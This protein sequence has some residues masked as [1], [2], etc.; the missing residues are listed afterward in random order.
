[1]EI[2]SCGLALLAIGPDELELLGSDGGQGREPPL[3]K[4]L[5]V[6]VGQKIAGEIEHG[7]A[8]V[9]QFYPRLA[10]TL[11]IG[12]AGY[13]FRLQLIEPK[14]IISGQGGDDRVGHPGC[15]QDWSDP[16]YTAEGAA[17]ATAQ[18]D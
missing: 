17:V 6:I 14:R 7:V 10:F 2:I 4:V 13:I 18:S 15:A 11:V 3:G 12:G 8:G 1:V 16:G 5:V 9:I